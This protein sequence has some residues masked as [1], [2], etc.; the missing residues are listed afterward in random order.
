MVFKLEVV[1]RWFTRF[2]ERPNNHIPL[3]F[4]N[5]MY[6]AYIPE[7]KTFVYKGRVITIDTTIGQVIGFRKSRSC[8]RNKK[9]G[10]RG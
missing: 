6:Y 3:N 9:R 2:K 10:K 1:E 5:V 8:Y 7:Y 4:G